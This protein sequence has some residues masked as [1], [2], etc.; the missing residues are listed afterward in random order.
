MGPRQ[1]GICGYLRLSAVPRMQIPENILM[2]PGFFA[3]TGS[4]YHIVIF[5][6]FIIILSLIPA[7]GGSGKSLFRDTSWL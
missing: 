6:I 3:K 5:P 2:K 7:D 4:G 1:T